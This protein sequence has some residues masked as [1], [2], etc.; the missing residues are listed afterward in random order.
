MISTSCAL[1]CSCA[2]SRLVAG[3]KLQPVTVAASHGRARR[4]DAS[5]AP[6]VCRAMAFHDGRTVAMRPLD[7]ERP[8][9]NRT[10]RAE[11]GIARC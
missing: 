7:A 8:P 11:Q 6:Y 1:A 9:A 10:P 3:S 4:T 5:V 2:P